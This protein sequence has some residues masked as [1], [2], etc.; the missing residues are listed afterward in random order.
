MRE[1]HNRKLSDLLFN[2]PPKALVIKNREELI[3]IHE[4]YLQGHFIS[5]VNKIRLYGEFE[6]FKD[7][8]L[9]LKDRYKSETLKHQTFLHYN[10]LYFENLNIVL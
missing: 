4:E 2:K 8:T 9:F 10:E 3:S 5:V 6:F 1:K 7:I